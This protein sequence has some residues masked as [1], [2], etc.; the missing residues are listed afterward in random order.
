LGIGAT[1]KRP[2]VVETAEGPVVGI[3]HRAMPIVD[4]T[5]G[6]HPA[7]T[8]VPTQDLRIGLGKHTKGVPSRVIDRSSSSRP[9]FAAPAGKAPVLSA[10]NDDGST[11]NGSLIDETTGE[12]SRSSLAILPP[13]CLKSPKVSKVLSLLHLHSLPSVNFAPALGQFLGSAARLTPA[14]VA[15]QLVALVRAGA[16]SD[17]CH[18]VERPEAVAA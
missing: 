17:R 6:P 18:L 2:A 14:T 9:W 12:R 11:P 16:R 3:R 4:R 1:V 15:R 10:V 5:L 8:S 13:W 7:S